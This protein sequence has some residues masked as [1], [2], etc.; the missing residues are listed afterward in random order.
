MTRACL[1]LSVLAIGWLAGT[2]ARAAESQRVNLV[3]VLL[4]NCGKEWFGCYGSEEGCTP[5]ID[6]LARQGM[7]VEHCYA[8][9]VCGPSRIVALTG[10]YLLRSG[11]VLHHDA[12]LYGGGGL[13]PTRE[14]T[15]ARLF[16]DAGYRTCI[17]GKW[18]INNLYDEPGVL[19]AHG[20]EHSLVWPGSIDRSRVS[21]EQYARFQQAVADS[22]PEFTSLFISN[23]ESRYWQPVLLRNGKRVETEPDDFGPDVMHRYAV[24]FLRDHREQPFLLYYP[25]VL[26][27]GQTFA[28]PTVATPLNRDQVRSPQEQY[29][30]MVRYA[31]R[32]VGELVKEIERCGLEERTVI[33]VATDNGTEKA[34]SA[35]AR[36]RTV[37]GQ[38][39]ELSEA[40]SDVP[41]LVY[42]PAHIPPG[43]TLPL[44]DFSD[45]L[46]TLCELAAVPIP[47]DLQLDGQSFAQYA[48]GAS[49]QPPRAWIF[50]QHGD[51]RIVR[52]AR[53][54]LYSDGSL[55]D[56]ESDPGEQIEL[57]SNPDKTRAASRQA[58]QAVLD[59]LPPDCPPPFELRSQFTFRLRAKQQR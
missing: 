18:Q 25:L 51:R 11:M 56:V 21:A 38:L 49:N 12:A 40:G 52:D 10:R 17:S 45:L 39:H 2:P 57:S 15:F 27:H 48:R 31:D 16:R 6:R 8:P 43:R 47:G 34:F 24:D 28:Y 44:A 50:N 7:L 26:T 35:R 41:L 55:F 36:G 46:P 22:D 33:V 29:A 4:D 30:D 3:F 23:I 59:S 13:D 20:F 37:Q 5:N 42:G 1:A 54:K 14:V 53:Y 58:L 9:P 32:L 19:E